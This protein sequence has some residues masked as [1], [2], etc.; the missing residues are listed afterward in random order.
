MAN[1]VR[2]PWVLLL[3]MLV[4]LAVASLAPLPLA[5]QDQG[6]VPGQT[7]GNT[8]DADF[9][10]AIRQ[11]EQFQTAVPDP[12]AAVMI[13][14]EGE[15]W[16]NVR[17]G[18]LSTYGAWILLGMTGLI[19]LF[20]AF[21]GRVR[22]ESGKSGH[23]IERFGFV[24]RFAHWL[25]AACFLV[26]AITG[27]NLLYGRYLLPSLIGADA[28]AILTQ[29]GKYLHNYLSFGFM[30]AL[31]LMFCLW[32]WHNIP[33]R[34]DLIWLVKAGGLFSTHSHP[35]S[36]KFNAGQ[37]IIFWSVILLGGSLSLSGIMLLFP[38]QFSMFADTFV[39]V[40]WALG[41]DLPTQLTPIEEQQLAHV[42]HTILGIVLTA[43]IL[44]HIYIGSIGMEGAFAAMGSGYVDEHW[45]RE[46]HDLWVARLEREGLM[47]TAAHDLR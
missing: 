40:N 39:W 6:R 31:V 25:G 27:L 7:L 9:W 32:V 2:R 12:K 28:F 20:F 47:V 5:A 21:R 19:A 17:N 24:E 34:L 16:R 36:K 3:L 46:H 45:A 29:G 26:L 18:P 13:Q 10:R 43:I 14:S 8:S 22:I 1:A 41:T 30:V 38:F 11:G 15:I 42:W 4:G 33:N 37:K 44:A 35:S 23:T